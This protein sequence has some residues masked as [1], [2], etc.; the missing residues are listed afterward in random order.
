MPFLAG[1]TYGFYH[2]WSSYPSY[3]HQRI[4]FTAGGPG[5][6]WEPAELLRLGAVGFRHQGAQFRP[7]V[8]PLG[9]AHGWVRRPGVVRQGLR[10]WIGPSGSAGWAFMAGRG[11]MNKYMAVGS[12]G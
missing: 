7:M 4:A 1:Y 5:P 3:V 6:W 11:V 9:Q 2:S 8:T 10:C 12:V